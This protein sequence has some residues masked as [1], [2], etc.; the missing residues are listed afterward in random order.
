MKKSFKLFITLTALILAFGITKAQPDQKTLPDF[1]SEIR[2]TATSLVNDLDLA[3]KILF[4]NIWRSDD[5][6]SRENNKE[7]LRVSN[8]YSQAKLKHGSAGVAFI[9]ICIDH[10]LYTWVMSTKKDETTSKFS[11][12]NST[13]KYKAL[14]K[15]FDGKTGSVVIGN[16]GTTLAR[17]IKKDD[18]FPLFRSFI[19][20]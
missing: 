11:L 12:E 17:D 9:N 1:G 20:R 10:E 16:D 5:M 2:S 14:V 7:F 3:N 19:T 15:Y 13:D 4:I 8:I 18:C 6:E